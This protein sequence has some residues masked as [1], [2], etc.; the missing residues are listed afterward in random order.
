MLDH[1][2]HL[3]IYGATGFTARVILHELVQGN[4]KRWPNDFKWALAGRS[5][6][7]LEELRLSLFPSRNSDSPGPIPFPDIVVADVFDR[8]S[9]NLMASATNLL[10]N[11][12]GPYRDY[13]EPVVQACLHAG[14]DYID[15]CGE[16]A[17]IEKMH[18][19][20]HDSAVKSAVTICHAAAFDSVPCDLSVNLCKKLLVEKGAYPS[21][22]EMFITLKT[23]TKFALNYA[24]YQAAI[25]GFSST[26]ELREMRKNLARLR[27]TPIPAGPP[28]KVKVGG[29][30]G[31]AA[32]S[33]NPRNGA[34]LVPYFFSDPAIVR[35][36]QIITL[37]NSRVSGISVPT[38]PPVHFAAHIEI[39]S[40]TY[41]MLFFV[42]FV[43][44]Q[45]L[46]VRSW[47]RNLLYSYPSLFSWGLV[48][49]KDITMHELQGTTFTE[50]FHA[51]GYSSTLHPT[52]VNKPDV[53][54]VVRV[55]GP[56]PGYI[57]TAI[58]FLET[59]SLMLR[60]RNHIR[61]GVLTPAVA[62]GD[63]DKTEDRGSLEDGVMNALQKDGR[64][65]W[66]IL[67]T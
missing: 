11:C 9:L 17:F 8:E 59:A 22:V 14:T 29:I 56:E 19:L 25:K 42:H 10:L 23:T 45:Y 51:R 20:Y 33:R 4:P 44:F 24:T 7:A 63:L 64:I 26:T 61:K 28:L 27:P 18:I 35:L 67:S 50:T 39:P 31:R 43:I 40:R 34:W 2:R 48:R 55:S 60:R 13:G 66:S 1:R 41:F 54:L 46:A 16:P 47:G 5:R 3:T 52:P 53:D 32:F 62:F 36:S 57:S 15:L 12:V 37:H 65:T 38:Y 30:F 58:I 6:N 21:S 49:N